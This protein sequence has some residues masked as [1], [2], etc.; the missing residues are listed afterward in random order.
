MD[1]KDKEETVKTKKDKKGR[2]IRIITRKRECIMP[3]PSS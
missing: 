3:P 1:C 2:V